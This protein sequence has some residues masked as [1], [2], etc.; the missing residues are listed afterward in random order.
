MDHQIQFQIRQHHNWGS[1]FSSGLIVECFLNRLKEDSFNFNNNHTL[2]RNHACHF[3]RTI[4]QMSSHSVGE[5]SFLGPV[6]VLYSYIL[7]FWFCLFVCWLNEAT[8]DH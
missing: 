6:G 7:F 2:L 3:N 4:F 1:I 8:L 5:H